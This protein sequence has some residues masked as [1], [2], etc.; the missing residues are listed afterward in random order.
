MKELYEG[1]V[2]FLRTYAMVKQQ[3]KMMMHAKN[4]YFRMNGF[5]R[6]QEKLKVKA[7]LEVN[8]ND[9]YN[10]IY[11]ELIAEVDNG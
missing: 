9:I 3:R 2:I 5:E 10:L 7:S 8:P 4:K 6:H 11:N 1:N